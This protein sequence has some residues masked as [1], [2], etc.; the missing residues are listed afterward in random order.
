MR[1]RLT[2]SLSVNTETAT[3]DDA[4]QSITDALNF[5]AR[6]GG[7]TLTPWAEQRAP[8]RGLLHL[9]AITSGTW[10]LVD[11]EDKAESIADPVITRILSGRHDITFD[12]AELK[13]V[14]HLVAEGIRQDRRM[15]TR[16]IPDDD[17]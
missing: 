1:A 8:A 9:R 17:F 12:D 3:P 16:I 6:R 4:I 7:G 2:L 5:Y 14:R 10:R 13:L 15:A 11:E